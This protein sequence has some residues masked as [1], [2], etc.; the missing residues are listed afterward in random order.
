VVVIF[1]QGNNFGKEYM[2]QGSLADV[3]HAHMQ[4]ISSHL[5]IDAALG[6]A[7]GAC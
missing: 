3:L 4:P 6:V 5:L 2:K 7:R 1:R